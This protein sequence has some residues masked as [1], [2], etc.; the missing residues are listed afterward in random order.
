MFACVRACVWVCVSG[1]LRIHFACSGVIH[2]YEIQRSV[3]SQI[4]C[5][6]RSFNLSGL[7]SSREEDLG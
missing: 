1:S 4:V 3:P 6:G 5:P 2:E 7:E